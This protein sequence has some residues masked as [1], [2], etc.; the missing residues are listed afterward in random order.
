MSLERKIR[1]IGNS[2]GIIIPKPVLEEHNLRHG[3]V[4][5]LSTSDSS[6]T[7]L[8]VD[9]KNV[10]TRKINRKIRKSED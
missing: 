5:E 8:K 1:K 9:G 7:F 3:D 10:E 2:Y 6:L 4:L